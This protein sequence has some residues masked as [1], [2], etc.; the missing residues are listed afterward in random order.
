MDEAT[1]AI[2]QIRIVRAEEEL[3]AARHL[4][5]AGLSRI[6]CSRAYYAA[7]LIT[8]AALL[9]LGITRGKHSGVEAA[10]HESLIRGNHLEPEY[11]KLYLLLR[12]GRE[13]SDYDDRV[14]VTQEIAEQRFSD[15][16]RYVARV[17][18]YLTKVSAG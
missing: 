11:G 12:R 1:A 10:L 3:L 16:A 9:T 6:S 15:A 2:I 4:I 17:R 7:F 5:E 13:D 8:T 14:I 18:Q